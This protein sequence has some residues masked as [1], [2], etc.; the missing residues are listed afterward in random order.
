VIKMGR[1]QNTS[2]FGDWTLGIPPNRSIDC[3]P[4]FAFYLNRELARKPW[5]IPRKPSPIDIIAGEDLFVVGD[6]AVDK[7]EYNSPYRKY[8]GAGATAD[9]GWPRQHSSYVD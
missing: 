1:W 4:N 5:K 6:Q 9:L 2:H 3:L 7:V 8:D